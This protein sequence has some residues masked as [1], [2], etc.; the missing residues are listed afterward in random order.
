[1]LLMPDIGGEDLD[2]SRVKD[3]RDI[4]FMSSPAYCPIC[5]W[6]SI[7]NKLKTLKKSV[8]H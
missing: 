6:F 2:F 1:M 3:T 7:L 8:N 5:K 4:E